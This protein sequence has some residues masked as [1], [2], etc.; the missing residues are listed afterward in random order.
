MT[1]RQMTTIGL[2]LGDKTSHVCVLDKDGAV[3]ERTTVSTN[4]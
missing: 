1:Q 4:S 3:I 2:D